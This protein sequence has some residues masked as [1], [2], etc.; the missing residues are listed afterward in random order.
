MTPRPRHHGFS[1]VEV[2]FAVV[3]LGIGCILVASIF[4]V[5]IQQTL[6]TADESTAAQMARQAM[7]VIET[8]TTADEYPDTEGGT[9]AFT[10]AG[11]GS[12]WPQISSSIINQSDPR[13]A[14]VPY[15][16]KR[17]DHT[18]LIT[19][20]VVRRA[21][22]DRYTAIDTSASGELAP[23]HVT[24]DAVSTLDDGSGTITF[25]KGVSG[26]FLS[27]APGTFIICSSGDILRV[28]QQQSESAGEVLW[29]LQPNFTLADGRA[30]PQY[31]GIIGRDWID[32]ANSP[33]KDLIPGTGYDGP[34]QD[35]AVYTTIFQPQ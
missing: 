3:V 30:A 24:I 19:I 26:D 27:I 7:Q 25:Q 1:F 22:H 16:C 33:D 18:I 21:V 14:W 13:Y 12:L 9:Q 4:P 11:T 17:P 35:V 8:N 34:A 32:P 28:G 6:S 20:V 2:M 10:D 23:R 5:A 15:F 29:S 31:A